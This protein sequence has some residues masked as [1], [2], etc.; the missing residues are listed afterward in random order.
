MFGGNYFHSIDDKGRIV[1]P[2]KYREELGSQFYAVRGMD[3]CVSLYSCAK[4]EEIE[5]QLSGLATTR[6]KERGFVRLMMASVS[7]CEM[8]AQGRVTL[9]PHLRSIAN[10]QKDVVVAGAGTH[11][12]IW[13]KERWDIYNVEQ[14]E[15][16]ELAKDFD[17]KL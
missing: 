8:N 6:P 9:P 15:F 16:E 7:D 14:G 11:V 3:K 17:V 2:V 4:W 12:E 5:S 10:L 13:D 1:I